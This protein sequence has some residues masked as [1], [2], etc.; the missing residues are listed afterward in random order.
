ML[1]TRKNLLTEDQRK[2]LEAKENIKAQKE[3]KL[4]ADLNEVF[5]TG[6]GLNVLR[7]LMDECGI[8]KQP[9]IVD[10]QTW[11]VKDKAMIY[12]GG[13]ISMYLMI[14]QRLNPSITQPV[15][16]QGLAKDDDIFS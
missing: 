14:R 2:A 6:A 5:G 10:P 15:E 3:A 7:W 11:D 9:I 13:R 4:R 1:E 8:F 12:N 16:N